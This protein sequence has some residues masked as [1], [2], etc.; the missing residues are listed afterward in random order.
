MHDSVSELWRAYLSS[1]GDSPETTSKQ[2]EVWH[3]GDNEKDAN[4]LADLANSGIKRA[5]SQ[6][7]WRLE[8]D[9][10]RL[11]EA[12]DLHIVTNWV[13]EARCLI[14]TKHI[15]LVPFNQ[16]GPEYAAMEGEGDKLLEYWRKVHWDYY[17]RE[18]KEIGK[19]PTLD[20]L[21]VCERFEVV[22]SR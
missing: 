14:Q 6:S 19:S 18:L 15:T 8:Y 2:F 4:E 21:I 3:F 12:G 22:Y 5:T 20:M 13:G 17:H 10:T 1:M 11:P 7:L 9:R 16:V